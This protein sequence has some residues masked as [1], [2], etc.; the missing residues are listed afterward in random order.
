MNRRRTAARLLA[1]IAAMLLLGACTTPGEYRLAETD[2]LEK[3]NRGVWGVNAQR[4]VINH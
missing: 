1:P 4:I 3:V 2:P